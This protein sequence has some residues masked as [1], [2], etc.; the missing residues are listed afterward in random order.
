[1]AENDG[2]V[3]VQNSKRLCHVPQGQNVLEYDRLIR[4]D[5]ETIDLQR[6]LDYA[7]DKGKHNVDCGNLWQCE[8]I[9]LGTEYIKERLRVFHDY[10]RKASV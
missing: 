3:R 1:M 4:I 2:I 8:T 10:S 5:S 6:N 9:V 7:V